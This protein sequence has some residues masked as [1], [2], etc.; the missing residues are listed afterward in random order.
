[1]SKLV[2]GCSLHDRVFVRG[3]GD[4]VKPMIPANPAIAVPA[5]K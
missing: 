1:M 4:A 5:L 3:T 2:I